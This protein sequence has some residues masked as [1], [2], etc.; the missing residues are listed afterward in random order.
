M[1]V[2]FF[3]CTDSGFV[4]SS[5][6][7]NGDLFSNGE[8]V[9]HDEDIHQANNGIATAVSKEPAPEPVD[10]VRFVLFVSCSQFFYFKL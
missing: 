7:V 8:I 3:L 2:I 10:F 9:H 6:H 1:D 4:N 5:K